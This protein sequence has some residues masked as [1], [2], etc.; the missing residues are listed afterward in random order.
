MALFRVPH[1]FSHLHVG[2]QFW[3]NVMNHATLL[4]RSILILCLLFSKEQLTASKMR[5]FSKCFVTPQ[6]LVKHLVCVWH[7]P[8]CW[9]P[10]PVWRGSD[11]QQG[12][13]VHFMVSRGVTCAPREVRKGQGIE[14][15]RAAV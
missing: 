5:C 2:P 1:P 15:V 14:S 11:N 4:M 7:H 12:E 6:I 10:L 3:E 8:G 9:K 13:E